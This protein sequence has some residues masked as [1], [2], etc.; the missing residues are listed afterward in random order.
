MN[1][2]H[3]YTSLLHKSMYIQLLTLVVSGYFA[4]KEKKEKRINRETLK[5]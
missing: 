2:V 3:M 4:S 1:V 5:K